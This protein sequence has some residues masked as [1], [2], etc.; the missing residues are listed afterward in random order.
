VPDL[1]LVNVSRMRLSI[2]LVDR[3]PHSPGQERHQAR[4]ISMGSN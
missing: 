3:H 1:D 4:W 2:C